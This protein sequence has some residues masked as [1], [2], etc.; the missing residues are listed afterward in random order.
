MSSSISLA[1]SPAPSR[2]PLTIPSV[3]VCSAH[4]RRGVR[5]RDSHH[6]AHVLAAVAVPEQVAGPE[7]LPHAAPGAQRAQAQDAGL[8]PDHVV[9]QPRH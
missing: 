9:A 8:L 3:T 5:K 1:L 7:G 2:L 4:A 6:P